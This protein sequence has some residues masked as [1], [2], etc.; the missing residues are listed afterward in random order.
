MP[1]SLYVCD[2]IVVRNLVFAVHSSGTVAGV[3]ERQTLRT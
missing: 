1:R 2:H 3:A